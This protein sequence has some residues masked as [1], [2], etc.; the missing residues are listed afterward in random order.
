MGNGS[1]ESCQFANAFADGAANGSTSTDA[2]SASGGRAEENSTTT[3]LTPL[4]I[5]TSRTKPRQWRRRSAEAT[6]TA[7]SKVGA[8]ESFLY[9]QR[10]A[11]DGCAEMVH[12]PMPAAAVLATTPSTDRAS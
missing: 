11:S 12:C 7:V 3:K 5:P 10:L 8:E 6:S 2:F 9:F 1:E 4:S